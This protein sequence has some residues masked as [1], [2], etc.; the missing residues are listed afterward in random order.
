MRSSPTEA[1]SRARQATR[2]HPNGL[3][4]ASWIAPGAKMVASAI[5]STCTDVQNVVNILKSGELLSREQAQR[6]GSLAHRT[7]RLPKSSTTRTPNGRSTCGC[8]FARGLRLS[9]SMKD[10]GRRLSCNRVL[11]ALSRSTC[12]STHTRYCPD[13]IA[14]SRRAIVAAGAAPVRIS[15]TD[16]S[17]MPFNLIY[18]HNAALDRRKCGRSVCPSGTRKSSFGNGLACVTCGTSC[19]EVR[20]STRRCGTCSLRLPGI[21]GYRKNRRHSQVQLVPSQ[22][23]FRRAGGADRPTRSIPFQQGHHDTRAIRR[24]EPSSRWGQPR[25]ARTYLWTKDGI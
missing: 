7:S 10:S 15:S 5:S 22:V 6:S 9:I 11:I 17:R 4:N 12:C 3:K 8:T 21:T 14:S 19:V 13:E 25:I 18:H 2:S 1:E 16:L 20:R 23:E 24:R